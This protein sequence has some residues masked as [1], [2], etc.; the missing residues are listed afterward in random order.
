MRWKGLL[1]AEDFCLILLM[2]ENSMKFIE[3]LFAEQDKSVTA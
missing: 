1:L 3:D 2:E